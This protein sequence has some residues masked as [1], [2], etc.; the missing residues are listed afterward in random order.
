MLDESSSQLTEVGTVFGTP[1]FM[2]PEQAQGLEVDE[3]ADIYSFGMLLYYMLTAQLPF[4]GLNKLA[5]LNKQ[6]H[7]RPERPSLLKPEINR[8]LEAVLYH[9]IHKARE[10]RYS[11]FEEVLVDLE[12]VGRGQRPRLASPWPSG[13]LPLPTFVSLEEDATYVEE[14]EPVYLISG[15]HPID[16]LE[17]MFESAP[18]EPYLAAA[19][20]DKKEKEERSTLPK[21]LIVNPTGS[22]S[23]EEAEH[24]F[25]LGEPALAA[26]E[27]REPQQD[28]LDPAPS[29][30][31]SELGLLG[32]AEGFELGEEPAEDSFILGDE[33]LM[34][35][36]EH[37]YRRS[38]NGG[39]IGVI[40][41]VLLLGGG[42]AWF[43]VWGP[44][45][46]A[47][48]APQEQ[49]PE[50]AEASTPLV[51]EPGEPSADLSEPEMGAPAEA[52]PPPTGFGPEP[53][54]RALT[55]VLLDKA[56]KLVAANELAKVRTIL[57]HLSATDKA[58]SK[59]SAAA[60]KDI[61]ERAEQIETKL[62]SAKRYRRK[63]R[64]TQVSQLAEELEGLSEV[65]AAQARE[66][67]VAC[68]RTA[69]SAPS[70][71]D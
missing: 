67:L 57:E 55:K 2:S 25:E 11:S 13:E 38:G 58:L 24:D 10:D 15:D 23:L 14:Q 19:S 26:A 56:R 6:V 7:E 40:L 47:E 33:V 49:P 48:E 30:D 60:L 43:F 70:T 54:T 51:G 35:G 34:E 5:I 64:C 66:L 12:H 46:S 63:L 28:L 65:A 50:Q 31:L 9:C 29:A 17:Q 8:E 36:E 1:E 27:S 20:Q 71:I 44:G 61:A 42:A 22:P 21:H 68:R 69:R 45:K 41:L 37:S 62:K 16:P 3:R 32:A 52:L 53:R 59:E 4:D 39:L 18:S